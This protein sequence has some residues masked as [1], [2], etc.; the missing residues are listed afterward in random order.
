LS[1]QLLFKAVNIDIKD[2]K[3]ISCICLD[4]FICLFLLETVARQKIH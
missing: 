1:E 4:F 3:L 2:D